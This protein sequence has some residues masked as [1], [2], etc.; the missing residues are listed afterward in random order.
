MERIIVWI[1]EAFRIVNDFIE[2]H[3]LY[4]CYISKFLLMKRKHDFKHMLYFLQGPFIFIDLPLNI[5]EAEKWFIKI[6]NFTI[7]KLSSNFFMPK[8]SN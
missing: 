4:N 5:V 2:K 8:F 3:K 1:I 6:W 7:S